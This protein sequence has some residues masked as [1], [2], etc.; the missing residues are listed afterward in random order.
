[1]NFEYVSNL[2]TTSKGISYMAVDYN[3]ADLAVVT[4]E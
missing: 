1:M 3:A 2:P 4:D